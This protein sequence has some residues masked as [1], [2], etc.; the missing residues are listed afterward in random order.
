M[1]KVT[2]AELVREA[3]RQ[4]ASVVAHRLAGDADRARTGDDGREGDETPRSEASAGTAGA[5][6]RTSR[7]TPSV[8]RPVAA[9]RITRWIE[10]RL[11]P[12]PVLVQGAFLEAPLLRPQ[13][14]GALP[15]RP[16]APPRAA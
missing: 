8:I 2:L 3:E 14:A 7:E 12:R 13:D 6:D 9:T 11:R 10:P 5:W 16:H 4:A 15:I 1:C